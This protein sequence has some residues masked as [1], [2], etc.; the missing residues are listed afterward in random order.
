M[1]VVLV[2]GTGTGVGKTVC[3]AALAA[4][5]VRSGRRV[6]VLKPAQTGVAPGEAGD[7]EEVARLVPGATVRELVRYPDPLAPAVAARRARM[8]GLSAERAA[9]AAADLHGG[10]DLVLVE[11][12]GG[13]L[14]RWDEAGATLADVAV[15]LSAPVL[16]VARAGL[17]TLNETA[18]TAEALRRRRIECT[19]VV[20]GSWP[21]EPGLAE[22]CNL[23]DL[24]AEAG[25]PLLGALPEAMAGLE[26]GEF[27]AC[28]EKALGL[29]WEATVIS[30]EAWYH[31]LKE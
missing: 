17:G 24:P 10:H 7:A 20:I 21:R 15:R 6:A 26:P 1:T 3:T 14:V 29:A 9:R 13:L 25:A 27:A 28:A 5:G 12:A 18:L 30:R 31:A 22:R 19:G 11:G 2:A 8:P 4:L 23:G 16:L